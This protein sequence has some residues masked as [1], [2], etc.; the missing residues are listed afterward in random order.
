MP[1]AARLLKEESEQNGEERREIRG[2][3]FRVREQLDQ[4][5]N[6]SI[7]NRQR[8]MALEAEQRVL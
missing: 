3:I 2:E 4:A 8:I 7:G 5:S 1:S 6:G